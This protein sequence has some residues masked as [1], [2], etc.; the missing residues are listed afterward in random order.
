MVRRQGGPKGA[1][2][3]ADNL[4]PAPTPPEVIRRGLASSLRG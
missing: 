4:T 3:Y 2:K 1:E